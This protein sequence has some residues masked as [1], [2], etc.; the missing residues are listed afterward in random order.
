MVAAAAGN[1]GSSGLWT[2]GNPGGEPDTIAIGS[3]DNKYSLGAEIAIDAA[4]DVRGKASKSIGE[5]SDAAGMQQLC[6]PAV[7]ACQ[8]Q[9]LMRVLAAGAA[10]RHSLAQT[11]PR[12]PTWA[13]PCSSCPPRW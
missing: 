12:A 7:H 3:T 8:L 9:L 4:I 5:S 1:D 6:M 11:P 2:Y 13:A 10:R